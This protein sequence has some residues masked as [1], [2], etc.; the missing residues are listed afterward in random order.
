MEIAYE[1]HDAVLTTGEKSRVV[2]LDKRA[3]D[4]GAVLELTVKVMD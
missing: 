2:V 4:A 1:A 3:I